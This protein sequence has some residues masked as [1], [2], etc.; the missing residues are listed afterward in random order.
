MIQRGI[1]RLREDNFQA[2]HGKRVGLLTNSGAVDHNLT[3]TYEIFATEPRVNLVALFSPEHGIVASALDAVLIENSVDKRT[4]VPI[5]S[6]YGDTKRPTADMLKNIDV[7]VCDI[8]D[9]GARFY[10]YIWT[11]S[12]ILEACGENNI[13]VLILDRPNPLGDIVAGSPLNETYSSFVGRFDIPIRHG[14][15]VGELSLMVNQR[16]NA[17]PANCTII[18]CSGW[19]RTT[20]WNELGLEFVP[21]SPAIP[22]F[23][24]VLHYTGSC[25]LEGTMLSEGRG[26]SL[27]FE[28]VGAP[29]IH[30]DS[31]AKRLNALNLQGVRFRPHSFYP[32]AGKFR[33][34]TCN[35]V[36]AHILNQSTFD[37]LATWLSVIVE[38]RNIYRDEFEWLPPIQQEYEQGTLFH[39]DRLIGDSEPRIKIDAGQSVDE[40]TQGWKDYCDKFRLYRQSFL[41][42]D[43]N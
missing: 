35:G 4:G 40:I 7:L 37:P 23:C 5:Y 33:D 17:T 16:W 25:F 31:L 24:T 34:E 27:P 32:T 14:M 12:Y 42:A 13:D 26:T 21:T 28:V 3:S 11:I 15:T 30:A 29:Y 8:Q 1:E 36:Q 38:I 18:P 39:F 2:L 10:T 9:I 19:K 6:L 20:L 41:I 22:H 43:Y